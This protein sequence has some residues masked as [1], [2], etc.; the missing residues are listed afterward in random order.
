MVSFLSSLIHFIVFIVWG[1]VFFGGGRLLH[2]NRL[3]VSLILGIKKIP[4]YFGVFLKWFVNLFFQNVQVGFPFIFCT[5][6]IQALV[7]CFFKVLYPLL[8]AVTVNVSIH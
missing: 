1:R 4:S 7:G 3:N 5:F 8:S 2:C 6:N